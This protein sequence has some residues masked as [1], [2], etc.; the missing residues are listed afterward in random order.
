MPFNIVL[1]W[2]LFKPVFGFHVCNKFSNTLILY[3][4]GNALLVSQVSW[5]WEFCLFFYSNGLICNNLWEFRINRANLLLCIFGNH[6]F[7]V[8]HS[9]INI[10]WSQIHIL[11]VVNICLHRHVLLLSSWFK[12]SL[13]HLTQIWSIKLGNQNLASMKSVKC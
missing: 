4:V 10:W 3:V 11:L 9:I 5:L 2:P 6:F 7:T 12:I 8:F 13:L 1:P